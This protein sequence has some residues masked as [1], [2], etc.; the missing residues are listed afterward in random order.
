MVTTKK[1]PKIKGKHPNKETMYS[2]FMQAIDPDN[3][4]INSAFPEFHPMWVIKSQRTIP[5][6]GQFMHMRKYVLGLSQKQCAAYLRVSMS[7]ISEWENNK[8]Q[9]PFVVMEVLRL[10]YESPEFRMS[11]PNWA[12]WFISQDGKLVCSDVRDLAFEPHEL[13]YVQML[14][15]Q[16][17]YYKNENERL[18]TEIKRLESEVS[19]LKAITSQGSLLE[20]LLAMQDRIIELSQ[21]FSNKVVPI[22]KNKHISSIELHTK[23]AKTA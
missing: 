17:S 11:H 3:V 10:V 14:Y 19:E 5:S 2:Y 15:S 12:G 4:A 23:E 13:T 7:T 20:E 6:G 18:R 16:Q 21:Q 1:K 8:K 9:V 22:H